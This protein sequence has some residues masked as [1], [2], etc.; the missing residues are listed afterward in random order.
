MT[1]QPAPSPDVETVL[2]RVREA[3]FA[4][5]MP[6]DADPAFWLKAI[7][8]TQ[9]EAQPREAIDVDRLNREHPLD[10]REGS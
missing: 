10:G 3:V 1:D 4:I 2:A 9:V 7:A 8:A 5:P 6:D